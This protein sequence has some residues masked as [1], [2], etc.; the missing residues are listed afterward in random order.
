MSYETLLIIVNIL[1]YSLIEVT[2]IAF[3]LIIA[4]VIIL[5]KQENTTYALASFVVF[6]YNINCG[7]TQFVALYLYYT[8][9]YFFVNLKIIIKFHFYVLILINLYVILLAI[10]NGNY[11]CGFP[12]SIFIIHRIFKKVNRFVFYYFTLKGR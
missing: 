4:L 2:I 8:T 1:F 7:S 6:Y 10:E 11:R 5:S 9:K 3:A 12:L